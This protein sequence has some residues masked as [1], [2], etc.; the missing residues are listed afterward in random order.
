MPGPQ[1]DLYAFAIVT[2]YLLTGRLPEENGEVRLRQLRRNVP[3]SILVLVDQL[4]RPDNRLDSATVLRQL[5]RVVDE[6][7]VPHTF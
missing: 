4:L 5:E 2:Y 1:A 6:E 7:R 3:E